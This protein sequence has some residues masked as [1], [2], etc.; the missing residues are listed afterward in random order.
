MFEMKR[1]AVFLLIVTA[2]FMIVSFTYGQ[3]YSLASADFISHGLK[4]EA[5]D[6]EFLIAAYASGSKIVGANGL[7]VPMALYIDPV[8]RILLFSF[9]GSPSQRTPVLRC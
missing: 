6:Q 8:E 4:L 3:Y 1:K 5:F 7:A 2:V 9:S